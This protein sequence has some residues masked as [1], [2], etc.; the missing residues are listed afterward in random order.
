MIKVLVFIKD[1]L[2]IHNTEEVKFICFTNEINPDTYFDVVVLDKDS[3]SKVGDDFQKLHKYIYK[4][5]VVE[6]EAELNAIDL[7]ADAWMLSS[8]LENI[9][10]PIKAVD[11]PKGLG[12][13][14]GPPGEDS[15]NS[16]R[17]CIPKLALANMLEGLVPTGVTV[18]LANMANG[19]SN[20]S[21]RFTEPSEGKLEAGGNLDGQ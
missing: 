7:K 14:S 12:K 11:G 19:S 18:I 8:K 3:V 2:S 21:P 6:N 16:G 15:K 5:V 4:I 9:C 20:A 1:D 13:H 10:K 17:Y